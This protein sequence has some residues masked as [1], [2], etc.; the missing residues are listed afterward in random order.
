MFFHLRPRGVYVLAKPEIE[1]QAEQPGAPARAELYLRRYWGSEA[2]AQALVPAEQELVSSC[3][4]FLVDRSYLLVEKRQRHFVKLREGE[5]GRLLP[6]RN[7]RDTVTTLETLP[8]GELTCAGEVINH[9]SAVPISSMSLVMQFPELRVQH[10]TGKLGLI[11]NSLLIGDSTVLPASYRYPTIRA[12]G[13]PRLIEVNSDFG[14]L[15]DDL[16]PR[17][18]LSGH[19]YHLDCW[20]PGHF[21]HVMTEVVG[22][23]WG[24][25]SAKQQ[26]PELKAIFRRRYPN[27]RHPALELAV[28][29]A[30]GIDP[31]DIVWVDEPVWLN[32]IVTATPMWQ[33][34]APYYVHP[35]LGRTWER[36][37]EGAVVKRAERPPRIF[38]SRRPNLTN[39]SCR[40][41][42]A[43][44]GVFARYGFAI[45]FPEELDLAEQASVFGNATIVAGFAGSGLFNI[46]YAGQ[47]TTLIVLSQE[48]YTARYE[49]LYTMLLGWTTHYFWSTPDIPQPPRRMTRESYLSA[50]DFDFDRNGDDLAQLLGSL[51]AP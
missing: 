8:R 40:N 24:W 35:Q 16:R 29:T 4:R 38:V 42:A 22:R 37:R 12:M 3:A 45:V 14:R 49:H 19:Y 15:A 11:S 18:V 51:E 13:N 7:T 30:F 1:G 9:E 10:Y 2:E 20:Y 27:E 46:C 25:P 43:V 26:F 50:W 34:Q 44:E 5:V 39:R 32:S 28:F 23:L 48:A 33:N 47:M 21:G 31:S 17:R 41:A 36:M 6:Q